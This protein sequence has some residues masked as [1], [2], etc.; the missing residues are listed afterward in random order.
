MAIAGQADTLASFTRSG[1]RRRPPT[2]KDWND[3]LLAGGGG[4][5]GALEARGLVVATGGAWP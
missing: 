4:V 3:A 5:C 2:G 1:E